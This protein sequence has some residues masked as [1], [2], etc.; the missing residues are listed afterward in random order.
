M[1][2]LR[3]TH[4]MAVQLLEAQHSAEK[5]GLHRIRLDELMAKDSE[6]FQVRM[7]VVGLR[8]ELALAKGRLVAFAHEHNLPTPKD[9]P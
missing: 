6:L 1:F 5:E 3:K 4:E 7:E 8:N 9:V 2:M